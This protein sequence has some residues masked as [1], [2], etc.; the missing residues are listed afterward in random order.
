MIEKKYLLV[1]EK[2]P[3]GVIEVWQ[4][5]SIR[6]LYI[7]DTKAI[8]SQ[9]DINYKENLLLE[10]SRAMMSF[11]L[12][13]PNPQAILLLGTG[14]GSIIHFIC[15][16]FPDVKISAVDINQKVL[17]IAKKYF[18]V[19]KNSQ[20]SIQIADAYSYMIKNKKKDYN[21]ILVDL[22]NGQTFPSFLCAPFFI[23]QCFESLSPEGLLVVN[24]FYDNE[25]DFLNLLIVLR[26]YFTHISLCM[27]LK[28]QKNIILF[29]FKSPIML[30]M[31][32]LR[33]KASQCQTKYGIEF[34]QFLEDIT[35]IDT[36]LY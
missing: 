2:S 29:A 12:F 9:L 34:E 26:Q 35:I 23:K 10:Y 30:D 15:Y 6:Y 32:Q 11:L 17:N 28:K 20:I 5:G 4:I 25:K 18:G 13:Q 14:G 22:H 21:V 3:W 16:W 36:K 19:F 24:V 31:I 27:T 1:S 8:Q 33:N 7:K